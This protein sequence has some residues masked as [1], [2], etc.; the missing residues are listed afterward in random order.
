VF[1]QPG[2][3]ELVLAKGSERADQQAGVAIGAQA[4][5]GFK[6]L[7]GGSLAGQPGIQARGQPR[8]ISPARPDPRRPSGKT[9]SRSDA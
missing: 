7:A 1:P 2:G 5:I 6:Q 8:S 4:Q 3:F 9:R